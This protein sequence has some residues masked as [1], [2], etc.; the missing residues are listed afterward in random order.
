MD[1]GFMGRPGQKVPEM[2]PE[3]CR[4]ISERYIEL[5]EHVTGRKFLPAPDGGNLT[6]RIETNILDCLATLRG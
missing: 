5:Y 3:I 2:T 4:S 1:N 6:R